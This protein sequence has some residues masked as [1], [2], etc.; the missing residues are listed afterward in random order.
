[1]NALLA[2]DL[3]LRTMN[4]LDLD[5][6]MAIE[7]QAYSF[8]WT[9][10]NFVDSLAAGYRAEMLAGNHCGIVGYFV[11]MPGFGEMHL[12]NLTVAPAWQRQ[13]LARRLLDALEERCRDAGLPML[14]LEVRA[15]NERARQLYRRRGF[16]E[17]GLRRGYYPAPQGTREDA[18]VMSTPVPAEDGDGLD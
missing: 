9:R 2:P 17:V 4:A 14:W 1:M 6:V 11:A 8:P 15:S 12:L 13:G 16:S 18:V 5:A 3:Q 7:A 10:G